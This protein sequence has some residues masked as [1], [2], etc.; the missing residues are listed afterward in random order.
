[1]MSHND[2]E[3]AARLDVGW[4][5]SPRLQIAGERMGAD[6]AAAAVGELVQIH[7]VEQRVPV[8]PRV[9]I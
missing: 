5:R 3:A 2:V 6:G 7:R 9:T 8:P 4:Q 1:M